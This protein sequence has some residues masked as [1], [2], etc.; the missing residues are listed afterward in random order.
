MRVINFAHGFFVM[1]AMFIS[2]LLWERWGITPYAALA[3]TIP[4][5]FAFGLAAY[6]AVLRPFLRRGA[7]P[8]VVALVT[9]AA[10]VVIEQSLIAL[11]GARPRSVRLGLSLQGWDPWG[12][13]VSAPRLVAA[14]IAIVT[15]AITSSL[16]KTT[17]W[18][19]NA[20]AVAQDPDAARTLGINP[21]R[22]SAVA[23]GLGTALAA[24][25]AAGLVTYLPASPDAGLS[26]SLVA[27]VVVVLGGLGSFKGAWLGALL[28]GVITNLVGFYWDP[29]YQT[30]AYLVILVVVLALRPRGLFGDEG[31]VGEIR[32]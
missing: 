30:P 3:L 21:D 17:R 24:I 10:A 26:Y 31:D 11:T 28:I 27:F 14:L 7:S 25:A 2:A 19:R 20:R 23:F 18:G 15:L 29:S 4:G 1:L 32:V 13:H 6:L 12:V 9:I 5:A 8:M 22:I 16:L